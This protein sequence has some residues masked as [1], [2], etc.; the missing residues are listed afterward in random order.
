M[1][2]SRCQLTK[3]GEFFHLRE[4]FADTFLLGDVM[5]QFLNVLFSLR[6]LRGRGLDIF[7]ISAVS[8]EDDRDDRKRDCKSI[9]ADEVDE[10]G[11]DSGSARA[12]EVSYRA[13]QI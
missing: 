2:D 10:G 12:G 6:C 1:C 7:K 9:D 8:Q 4:L 5:R 13:P 3:R 11:D